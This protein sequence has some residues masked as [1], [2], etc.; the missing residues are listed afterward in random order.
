[1]RNRNATTMRYEKK[2]N[3]YK[4]EKNETLEL[5]GHV[6]ILWAPY[7]SVGR[8]TDA[9]LDYGME[10]TTSCNTNDE[11]FPAKRSDIHMMCKQVS[12]GN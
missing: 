8:I 7:P 10:A 2:L 12:H 3:G 11:G 6:P 4:D 5:E 1:L 9:P